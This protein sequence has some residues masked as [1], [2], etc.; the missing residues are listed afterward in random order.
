ML[1]DGGF[2]DGTPEYEQEQTSKKPSKK[3]GIM[4]V[5][6]RETEKGEGEE[7]KGKKKE[8]GENKHSSTTCTSSVYL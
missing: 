8:G 3:K 1:S 2:S 5:R 6:E 4:G 7:G